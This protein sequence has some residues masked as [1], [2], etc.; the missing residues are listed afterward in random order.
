MLHG[1]REDRRDI[2][3]EMKR[4][5]EEFREILGGPDRIQVGGFPE[6]GSHGCMEEVE[7]VL[8]EY[9]QRGQFAFGSFWGRGES[10]QEEFETNVV[11]YHLIEVIGSFSHS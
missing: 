11:H 1:R 7:R 8:E 5:G 10:D 2:E 3:R 9:S 4:Y 6:D